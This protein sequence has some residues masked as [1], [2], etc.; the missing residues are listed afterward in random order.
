MKENHW[1]Q[2]Y[3][4]WYLKKQRKQFLNDEEPKF[5]WKEFGVKN[6]NTEELKWESPIKEILSIM[7]LR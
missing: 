3:N 6:S 4:Y 7:I 1:N 2:F 5:K